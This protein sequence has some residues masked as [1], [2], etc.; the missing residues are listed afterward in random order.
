MLFAQLSFHLFLS[1][2]DAAGVLPASRFCPSH[3][4]SVVKIVV[5]VSM[6]IAM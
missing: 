5:F 6:C 3:C 4:E 1:G 2:R